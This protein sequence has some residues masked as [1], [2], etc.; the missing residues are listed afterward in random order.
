MVISREIK[1]GSVALLTIIL[2]I[3]MYSFLKGA[4]LLTRTA[5]YY[6]VYNEIGGLSESNPIE[7]SGYKVGVVQSIRFIDD[8]TG[9]LLVTLSLDKKMM[10]PKGS[11]AEITTATLIAGM[12]IQFIFSTET[13]VHTSGDTIAGR[14]AVPIM[15]RLENEL[16]PLKDAVEITV[17]RLDSMVQSLN[18]TLTPSMSEDLQQTT[19]NI[20][21][22]TGTLA[23]SL[24]E[25]QNEIEATIKNLNRFSGMLADN[26]ARFDST[27]TSITAITDSIAAA[28]IAG[29][30]D[31]LR[32]AAAQTASLLESINDGK[33][34][35]GKL[36]TDD[37][38]YINLNNSL[39]NLSY[40]LED[41]QKNPKRYVH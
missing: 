27:I 7:V 41:L 10:I 16:I 28:D 1:I 8:G 18:S 31:R 35:A 3:W 26:T 21:S 40:L 24:R 2:F 19:A 20:N 17:L 34:S 39:A 32:D 12:K 6:V 37:S 5:H 36:M 13:G 4:N 25:N 29:T 22:I 11:V 38:V 9:R 15:T 30:I 33:G 14:L 23:E